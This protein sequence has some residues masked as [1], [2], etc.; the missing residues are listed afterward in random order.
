MTDKLAL[1]VCF[2]AMLAAT[3]AHAHHARAAVFTDEIIEIEGYVTDPT[4]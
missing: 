2:S 3:S 4:P 1:A